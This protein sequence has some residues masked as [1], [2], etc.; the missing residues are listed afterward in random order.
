MSSGKKRHI[1]IIRL[2]A[3]GDVAISAPL[4]REYALRNPDIKFT[5]VSQKLME[6]F[7]K[8]IKN[9]RFVSVNLK[10]EGDFKGMIKIAAGLLKLKPT[11]LADIH[12]VLRSKIIR[13][14]FMLH[15]VRSR[16]IYKNRRARRRLTRISG[17]DLT[18]L[19]TSMRNYEKVLTALGLEDLGFANMPAEYRINSNTGTCIRKIGIAPFAKHKGK[20]WPLGYM[21][22]VVAELSKDADNR[23]MLFGGGHEEARILMGW[24]QKYSNTESVAGKY[25]LK[26]ELDIIKGLDVMVTMDSANMHFASYVRTPVV[27]VWG[28]THPAAGF[29]G[30]GQK[31]SD[32]V[33]IDLPCRPCSVYGSKEC[34]RGDYACLH[35]VT[36]QMVVKKIEEVLNNVKQTICQDR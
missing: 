24:E 25:K 1:L 18:P 11:D 30:W 33:Q 28:A 9:L 34:Y 6:P 21:E 26:E 29:Y 4:I 35:G 32:A 7:F 14:Y 17:K 36:P 3:L 20:S 23:V 19:D 31:F 15:G 16:V 27:S 13:F 10:Q 8:G 12:N 22:E 2:S 5:M